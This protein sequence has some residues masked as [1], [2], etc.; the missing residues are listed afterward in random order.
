[1][2]WEKNAPLWPV[3]VPPESHSHAHGQA[4][5]RLSCLPQWL[6][7]SCCSPGVG[8]EWPLSLH[9]PGGCSSFW[10][11]SS[12]A[13]HLT[14]P[15]WGQPSSCQLASAG[16]IMPSCASFQEG[17]LLT[18]PRQGC[19]ITRKSGAGRALFLCFLFAL[20]WQVF[21]PCSK[22]ISPW[23]KSK[24]TWIC[25]GRL[26]YTMSRETFLQ[27]NTVSMTHTLWDVLFSKNKSIGSQNQTTCKHFAC[28]CHHR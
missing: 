19:E 28:I 3:P 21:W 27:K 20:M 18:L 17:Q 12:A 14:W 22:E 7:R 23:G 5:K 6:G 13:C 15:Q 4:A 2:T 11:L 16:Y 8:M 10:P 1:M 9:P 25:K 26:K 24:R